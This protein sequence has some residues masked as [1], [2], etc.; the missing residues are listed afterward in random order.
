M[1]RITNFFGRTIIVML[2]MAMPLFIGC[3]GSDTREAI[4][5]TVEELAGKKK[6]DQMKKME[7]GVEDIQNQQSNRLEQLDNIDDK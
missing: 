7:N 3:K 4:D 6:V 1:K 5:D 2:L